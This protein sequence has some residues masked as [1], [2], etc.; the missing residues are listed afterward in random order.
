[1]HI[2]YPR[3]A[4]PLELYCRREV[5]KVRPP[6]PRGGPPPWGDGAGKLGEV[7]FRAARRFE[8]RTAGCPE[9]EPE[10]SE[11]QTNGAKA[12]PKL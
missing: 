2:L 10:I 7:P 5:K 8:G 4:P 9:L 6:R 1:M 3:G 11:I 12:R